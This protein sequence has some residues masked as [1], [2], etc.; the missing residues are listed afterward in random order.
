MAKFARFSEASSDGSATVVEVIDFS[1]A[2]K[3]HPDVAKLFVSV[4][5]GAVVGSVKN[6]SN[7]THPT[8]DEPAPEPRRKQVTPPEFL[9]LFTPAERIAIRQARAYSGNEEDKQTTALI[10]D[11][12]FA[13]I[14]DPRLTL[15][16]L[17]LPQT[18]EGLGFLVSEGII[19]AERKSEIEAGLPA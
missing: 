17:E 11:D 7:W 6:G 2:G 13:I 10:L 12:W 4:P 19:S 9:L 8:D 15:V 5:E 3:F 16:D 14:E 1:P 18:Q